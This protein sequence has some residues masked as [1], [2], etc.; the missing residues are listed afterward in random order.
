M[1]LY[2]AAALRIF[3]GKRIV[4]GLVWTGGPFLMR[5]SEPLLDAQLGQ[6]RQ[7]LDPEEG[8]S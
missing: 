6:I 7:R 8:R 4:C 3:P 2:R 1:A 5:L